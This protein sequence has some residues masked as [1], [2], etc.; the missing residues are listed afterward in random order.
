MPDCLLIRLHS[1]FS[2]LRIILNAFVLIRMMRLSGVE[3]QSD[4]YHF[5]LL[6]EVL[7]SDTRV[8]VN[9]FCPAFLS[10]YSEAL[11]L[12]QLGTAL[13]GTLS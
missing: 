1:F 4:K 8:G 2:N 9:V 11:D 6:L 13:P 12:R 3:K 5:F 7:G 10:P